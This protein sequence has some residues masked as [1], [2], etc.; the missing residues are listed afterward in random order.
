MYKIIVAN[1]HYAS[2]TNRQVSLGFLP[3]FGI[4]KLNAF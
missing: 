2:Y 1:H 3:I 4:F